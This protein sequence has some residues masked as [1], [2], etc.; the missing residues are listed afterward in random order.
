MKEKEKESIIELIEELGEYYKGNDWLIL[1]KFL[2]RY[3]NPAIRKNFST[4]DPKTKKH[5]INMYEKDIIN[6]Y[7]KIYNIKLV[8]DDSKKL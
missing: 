2:L 3:L 8:L 6:L 4:R 7:Y 1:K 5:I